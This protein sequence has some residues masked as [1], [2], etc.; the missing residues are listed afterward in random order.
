MTGGFDY[1]FFK[2][3]PL[4]KFDQDILSRYKSKSLVSPKQLQF[5]RI[6]RIV[7]F[8]NNRILPDFRYYTLFF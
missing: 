2:I 4:L 3:I 5:I 6:A 8:I 7:F 1:W